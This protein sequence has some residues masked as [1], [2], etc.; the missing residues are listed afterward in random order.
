MEYEELRKAL[1]DFFGDTDRTQQETLEGLQALVEEAE[2]LIQT[3]LA[4]IER[5][6]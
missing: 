4:D 5:D 2:G 1:M 3:L 6:R